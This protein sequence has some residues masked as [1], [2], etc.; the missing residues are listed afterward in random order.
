MAGPSKNRLQRRAAVV[1]CV[2]PSE[3]V[4]DVVGIAESSPVERTPT[5]TNT[6]TLLW[7]SLVSRL[8]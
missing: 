1:S 5:F 4:L 7:L 6:N 3:T 8:Y 2:L